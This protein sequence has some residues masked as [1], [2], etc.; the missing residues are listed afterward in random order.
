L[1]N[2]LFYPTSVQT[3]NT[4]N[5]QAASNAIGGDKMDTKLIWDKN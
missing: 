3:L 1:P 2:R 4:S 5:Y